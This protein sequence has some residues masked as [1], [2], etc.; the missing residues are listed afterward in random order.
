MKRATQNDVAKLAGTSRATVSYVLNGR[1]DGN[2]RVG[3]ETRQKIQD[4]MRELGY[5]VNLSARSLK[6][7][8]SQLIAVLVPDLGNP[9]YPML[10]RGAQKQARTRGYRILTIDSLS[11]EEG[12]Q[13]FM[14]SAQEHIADGVI[15]DS[16]YLDASDI[17]I[18]Q[19]AGIPCVG[20]GPR[21]ADMGI[22][23][24][25]I[26]QNAA[27]RTL[28]DHLVSRGH[29]KIAHLTGDFHNINGR[30]RHEAFLQGME[31]HGLAVDPRY[32]LPGN[33]L[34]EGTAQSV[35]KWLLSF[36]SGERP[37]ALF[38][39]ND[40]MAIEAIK[41]IRKLGLHVPE[42]FAVCGFDNIPEAE[43]VEPPLTTI[44]HDVEEMGREAARL[45]IDRVEGDN[46][47]KAQK[48]DLAFKLWVRKSS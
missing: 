40:L 10:I 19:D 35:E 20:I 47:K 9:F 7:N 43:Y 42:D 31:A 34:R 18:L 22:D 13:D 48:R 29:S 14:E 16:T 21:L 33:F 17:K 30:V 15:M 44:G 3:D 11:S 36:S 46:D 5:R 4:A 26:D 45:L 27:V 38:A 6:T 1:T 2:I 32:I 25:S 37:S 12:E 24:I 23:I 8:R 39:A 28:L 41:A